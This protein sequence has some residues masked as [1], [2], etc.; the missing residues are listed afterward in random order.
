SVAMARARAAQRIADA[1]AKRAEQEILKATRIN[2]FLRG[3]LSS[4]DPTRG[5]RRDLTVREAVDEAAKRVEKELKDEPDV[6]SG[7]QAT[8]ASTYFELGMYEQAEQHMRA[9]VHL[10]R[11]SP[12]GP[13][14][15]L[16]RGISNLAA[17][18]H[19]RGDYASAESLLREALIMQ[20]RQTG[21]D[22][23]EVA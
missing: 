12:N 16:P 7:L 18:L 22:D 15:D 23:P 19:K 1:N 14:P 2:R 13:P 6:P 9:A 10:S 21:N 20:R 4:S 5:G 11:T 17:V 3:M 8:I